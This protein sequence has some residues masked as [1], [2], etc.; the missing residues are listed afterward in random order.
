MYRIGECCYQGRTTRIVTR[1]DMTASLQCLNQMCPRPSN[2]KKAEE[3]AHDSFI[4]AWNLSLNNSAHFKENSGV[5]VFE[6][7]D[8]IL[9]DLRIIQKMLS[10]PIRREAKSMDGTAAL[11]VLFLGI[12]FIPEHPYGG[13][14][15][16]AVRKLQ[17]A[18][19]THLMS[20]KIPVFN[21]LR[22]PDKHELKV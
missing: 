4:R 3:R 18:Q 17:A 22:S 6:P 19:G 13:P 21:N 10:L 16:A 5:K 9:Q 8:C 7:H 11:T 2:V 20:H 14:V 1:P 15:E 12:C